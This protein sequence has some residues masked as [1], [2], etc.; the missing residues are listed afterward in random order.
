MNSINEQQP[1]LDVVEL[2]KTI[3]RQLP[4]GY[5]VAVS[6]DDRGLLMEVYDGDVLIM[7]I[8]IGGLTQEDAENK[9]MKEIG[10]TY[11]V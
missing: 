7:S 4:P 10:D 9:I 1:S 6:A 8:P 11:E 2:K 5:S 3:N